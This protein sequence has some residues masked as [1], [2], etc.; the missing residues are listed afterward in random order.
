MKSL[1]LNV[2]RTLIALTSAIRLER[3]DIRM[4]VC[5]MDNP[6]HIDGTA[7]SGVDNSVIRRIRRDT[8][9]VNSVV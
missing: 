3:L 5:D 8:F 9:C 7:R 2:I 6:V 1:R 4:N